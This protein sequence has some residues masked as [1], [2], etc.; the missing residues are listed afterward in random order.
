MA[1]ACVGRQY[2]RKEIMSI[3]IELHSLN[4]KIEIVSQ[5]LKEN[6]NE[7][8][9]VIA[10]KCNCLPAFVERQRSFIGIPKSTK[11]KRRTHVK[12]RVVEEITDPDDYLEN[13]SNPKLSKNKRTRAVT[14]KYGEQIINE[15]LDEGEDIK[16]ISE[17]YKIEIKA[18]TMFLRRKGIYKRRLKMDH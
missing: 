10:E 18:L 3:I 16:D 11:N 5:Y 9:S 6:P 17:K 1:A 15:Y 13:R 7:T 8:D 12:E 14:R 2:L 4:K